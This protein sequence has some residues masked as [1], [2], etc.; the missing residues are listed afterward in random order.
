M[1][2]SCLVTSPRSL[3]LLQVKKEMDS[4]HLRNM[5]NPAM[6]ATVMV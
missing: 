2:R 4:W 6:E 1:E 5:T 3:N